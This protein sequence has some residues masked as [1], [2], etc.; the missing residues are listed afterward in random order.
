MGGGIGW[1]GGGG[2][3]GGVE[4]EEPMLDETAVPFAHCRPNPPHK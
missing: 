1:G 3:A 2:G 4:G